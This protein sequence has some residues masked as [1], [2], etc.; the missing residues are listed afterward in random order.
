MREALAS[1][2]LD[3][4]LQAVLLVSLL[5]AADR[6]DSTTGVQMAFLK[7]WAPRALKPIALRTPAI[8]PGGGLALQREAWEAAGT[9]ADLAYL[10]PPYNQHSYRGNYHVWETLARWDRPET[11]GV[12]C[13]RVDCRTHKS[14]FNSK[15]TIRP[16]LERVLD[17]LRTRYVL[18]SFSDEGYVSREDI[19]T[20]LG[21][22]GHVAV[23][24]A[25]HPRY[26]GARIGIHD[27]QGRKVGTVGHLRNREYLYVVARDPRDLAQYQARVLP[28]TF[29]NRSSAMAVLPTADGEGR[30][31]G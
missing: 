3:P 14:L 19:E 8:V 27:P 4:D 26:V 30:N 13:K 5:E 2:R 7:A 18:L 28:S 10:D 22:Y 9:E 6:V 11:Y 25:E 31:L 21:R 20:M 24:E 1:W 29:A 15:R 23:L 12:A 16:A 17:A